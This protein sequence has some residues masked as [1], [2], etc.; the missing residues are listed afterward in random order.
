M[1]D[2]KYEIEYA[3]T[4]R[5]KCK[6]SK[7]KQ[8]IEKDALRIGKIGKNP[9]SE[10]ED[11]TKTDW[12]HAECAFNA[13]TRARGNTKK[14]DSEDDL[15]NLDSIKD[16]DQAKVRA[17]IK[18]FVDAG[19]KLPKEAKETK[20]KAAAGK[21]KKGGDDEDGDDDD[22]EEK[23]KK[24]KAAPKKKA[25]KAKKDDDEDG[26]DDDEDAAP[27]KKAKA[28]AAKKKAAPKKKKKAADDEDDGEEDD[29]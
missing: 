1:A 28:P 27:A 10:N 23:P 7:C 4:G 20:K 24:R 6:D 11:D 17:L 9:F 15:Q 26:D 3:K 16:A 22:E 29:E 12:F 2:N 21:K 13:L 8:T 19:Y 18:K 14:I 5:A 25:S